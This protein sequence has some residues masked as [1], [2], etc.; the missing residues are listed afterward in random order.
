[1][2]F[3][4][5]YDAT[6]HPRAAPHRPLAE[7]ANCQLYAYAFLTLFGRHVPAHRSSELWA[8]PTLPQV[9]WETVVGN[10]ER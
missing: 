3:E 7:G 2:G 6:R 8:D 4:T 1:M 10:G 5:P 9:L